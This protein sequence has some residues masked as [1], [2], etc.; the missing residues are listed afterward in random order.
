M[1][2]AGI[3]GEGAA[4]DGCHRAGARMFSRRRAPLRPEPHPTGRELA[5]EGEPENVEV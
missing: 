1:V 2:P 5:S 4:A 3:L